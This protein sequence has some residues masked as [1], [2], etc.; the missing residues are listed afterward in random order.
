MKEYMWSQESHNNFSNKSHQDS[1]L[2]IQE[3]IIDWTSSRGTKN[4]PN[5]HWKMKDNVLGKT[6]AK[7]V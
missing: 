1:R 4:L 5:K 7:S 2:F 3:K 6:K